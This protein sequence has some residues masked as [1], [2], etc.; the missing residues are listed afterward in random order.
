ML[1]SEVQASSWPLGLLCCPEGASGRV[2]KGRGEGRVLHTHQCQ[3]LC[4][5]LDRL[6]WLTLHH[7]PLPIVRM[8]KLRLRG[9]KCLPESTLTGA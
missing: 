2:S 7:V 6:C 1:G 9:A 3:A 8:M 5:T 4:S